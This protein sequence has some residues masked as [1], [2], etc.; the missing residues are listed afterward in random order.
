MARQ[1][2]KKNSPKP[3]G[4]PN[5]AVVADP[6]KQVPNGSYD[7]PPLW[8]VDKEFR[9]VDCGKEET[10]TASQQKWYYEEAKGT[11]YATAKRCHEC[12]VKIRDAKA[13]QREQM[14]ASVK[15]RG[16]AKEN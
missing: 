12:R 5:D 11:L 14:A 2:R 16:K 9:C 6:L 13:L 8:Y 4:M 3:K 1:H 7:P 10:W 15:T